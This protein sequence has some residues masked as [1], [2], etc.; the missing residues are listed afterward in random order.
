M[1]IIIKTVT[2]GYDTRNNLENLV[3]SHISL[4]EPNEKVPESFWKNH[5]A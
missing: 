5:I 2:K 3:E 1:Q 4:F